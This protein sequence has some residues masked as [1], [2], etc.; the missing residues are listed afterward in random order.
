M[1]NQEALL[2]EYS[3]LRQEILQRIQTNI[4]I[5][6]AA[7]AVASAFTVYGFQAQ[8]SIAFLAAAVVPV[9]TLFY[10]A[11]SSKELIKAATYIYALIE[12]KVEGLH[13]ETMGL[14]MRTRK[15]R[16][17]LGF[18]YPVTISIFTLVSIAALFFA[19]WFL[20]DYRIINV[21]LYS[22]ITLVLIVSLIVVSLYA[23]QGSSKKYHL[24]CVNQWKKLEEELYS[25]VV[26]ANINNQQTNH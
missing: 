20:K 16:S 19:W 9:G 25:K 4:Q 10:S 26:V 13:W 24:D 2:A 1:A 15:T 17:S 21:V 11:N 8:N 5:V 12:P 7:A 3:T 23:L 18:T 14:E 22:G 6:A